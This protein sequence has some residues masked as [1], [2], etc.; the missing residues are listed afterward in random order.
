MEPLPELPRG[1]V[2]EGDSVQSVP[3]CWRVTPT[4]TSPFFGNPASSITWASG[5]S[6]C[7]NRAAM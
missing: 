7:S 4:E 3:E 1:E 5:R 6:F 2:L